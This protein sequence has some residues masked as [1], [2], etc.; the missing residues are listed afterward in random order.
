MKNLINKSYLSTTVKEQHQK[1]FAE[2]LSSILPILSYDYNNQ[3][4]VISVLP[5]NLIFVLTTLKLHSCCQ[6]SCLSAVSGV[7]YPQRERRFE[8]VYDLLSV[9]YNSRVRVKTF[10]DEI[11]PLTSAVSVFPAST[12]WER[13]VWDL[14]GVFFERNDEI[15]RILTDYGFEGHP[16]RKDFPLS[17]Y[18]ESRYDDKLKRVVCEP[19]EH[20][21]EFRSF[22]FTSGWSSKSIG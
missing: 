22:D 1:N 9:K 6:Y 20:A 10:V 12:W 2:Y 13:E 4:L 19:L 17:G 3:T 18:V 15:K 11:T 14:F 16:L 5:E 21:Q 7:D 8:V